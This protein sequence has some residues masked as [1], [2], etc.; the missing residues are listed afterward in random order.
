MIQKRRKLM[1]KIETQ[2]EILIELKGKI[3]NLTK[4]TPIQKF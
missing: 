2:Y 4:M 1:K 3:E